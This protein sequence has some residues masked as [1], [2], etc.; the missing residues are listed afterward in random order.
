MSITVSVDND[1]MDWRY[2]FDGDEWKQSIPLYML[3]PKPMISIERGRCWRYF[4][5]TLVV[6]LAVVGLV[7]WLELGSAATIGAGVGSFL[8]LGYRYS[9]WFLGPVEWVTFDTT[10]K[11]KTVYMFRGLDA[12]EFEQ[13][14]E[15][16]E[17]AIEHARGNV[18]GM[19]EP[20]AAR[21]VAE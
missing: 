1:V 3:L 4:G 7:Q 15:R 13:F 10:L 18:P 21:R 19:G 2:V 6:P 20:S 8:T 14:I 16:L 11:D 9:P 5:L 12:S 17:K